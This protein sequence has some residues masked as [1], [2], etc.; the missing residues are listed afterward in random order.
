SRRFIEVGD[1]GSVADGT[2]NR[3]AALISGGRRVHLEGSAM[4]EHLVHGTGSIAINV[5][6]ENAGAVAVSGRVGDDDVG[7]VLAHATEIELPGEALRER[8]GGYGY[9]CPAI[10]TGQDDFGS[11]IG[12]QRE[13]GPLQLEAAIRCRANPHDGKVAGTQ[14]DHLH[15]LDA[16]R[17]TRRNRAEFSR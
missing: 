4:L 11:E 8:D 17:S 1:D 15:L 14:L 12:R 7:I 9:G 5:H 3:P 2:G 13:I 16:A 10:T 6:G